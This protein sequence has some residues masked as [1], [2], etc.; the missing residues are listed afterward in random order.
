M[1]RIALIGDLITEPLPPGSNLLVEYDAASQW[2]NA[3]L[4]VAAG[5]LKSGGAV[6]YNTAAQPSQVRLKL[7]KL[8]LDV[9][10]LEKEDY[11]GLRIWDW[12]AATRGAKSN[13]R[14]AI[15]SLKVADLSIF[16]MGDTKRE[17]YGPNPEQLLVM[18][19]LSSLSRFN[20]ERTWVEYELTR[21]FSLVTRYELTGL[22]GLLTGI[23]SDSVY[24]RLEAAAD[25]VID[26]K[27]EES[28]GEVVN[29]MRIRT[30]RNVR[31]DSRW[32]R[33]KVEENFEVTLE[34]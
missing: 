32:H 12:F 4:T 19:D 18:D 7:A 21:D 11:R 10:K 33:L 13:E 6:S 31:L 24:K 29:Q 16:T 28:G 9:Q 1:P 27:I 23:H 5:W 3:S 20:D 22:S 8:G 17:D 14:L 34:K 2:Y 15:A 30:M 25:D 26:F